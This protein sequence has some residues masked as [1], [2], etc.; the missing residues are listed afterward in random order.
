MII[1][2]EWVS[3]L[4]EWAGSTNENLENVKFNLVGTLLGNL[5]LVNSES[6]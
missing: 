5:N 6:K 1:S 3:D 2:R 4:L